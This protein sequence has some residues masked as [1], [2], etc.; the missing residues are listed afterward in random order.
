MGWARTRIGR[1]FLGGRLN[2][3]AVTLAD[4]ELARGIFIAHVQPELRLRVDLNSALVF[5][6]N[7]DQ[8]RAGVL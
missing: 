5:S 7:G 3:V 2:H 1:L 4:A 6:S 8:H